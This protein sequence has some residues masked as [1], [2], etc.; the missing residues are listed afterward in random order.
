MSIYMLILPLVKRK[1]GALLPLEVDICAAARRL[2]REFHGFALAK[3]LADGND[4]KRLIA[5]GTLY[6]ALGR[7]EAMGMLT[8]RWED[9]Q[10]ADEGRP[11]RRLYRLTDLGERALAESAAQRVVR[12][13]HRRRWVPA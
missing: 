1:A 5:Q 12:A 13:G 3:L 10:A 11:L 9:P 7:L 2:R 6:R 8:S 4:R